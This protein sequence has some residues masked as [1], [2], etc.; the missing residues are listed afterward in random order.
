TKDR[1]SFYSS[2]DIKNWIKESEFGD[3]LGAHGGVWECPDLF[4]VNH[5]GD[6]HW[7]LLVSINPGGPNGGSATQ[8]F[9]GQFDGKNFTPYQ[10]DTRWVDYGPDNYAGVTWSNTGKRK[11]FLGWMSN[12]QYANLVPTFPWRSSMTV[13]RELDIRKIGDKLMLISKPARELDVL[14]KK[15]IVL[16]EIEASDFDLT[17]KTGN[18]T[19]PYRLSIHSGKLETFTFTLSNEL[20]EKVSFG[21]D[22]TTNQYFIDRSR[23]GHTGFEK[24]FGVKHTAPRLVQVDNIDMEMIID[25]SSLE[26]FADGGLSAMSALFFPGIDY[27]HVQINSPGGFRI[28]TLTFHQME[29]SW[30]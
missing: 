17:S 29:S 30:K 16:H 7:V 28:D 12:W 25:N 1:I 24:G 6:T 20:G 11:L 10:T 14:N 3:N 19:G 18:I 23:S 21:Y 27:S 9:T 15:E 13:P 2:A 4:P 8:Y 5:N 26:I 22:K